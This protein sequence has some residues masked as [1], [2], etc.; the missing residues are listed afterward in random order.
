MLS[1]IPDNFI[2]LLLVITLSR[3]IRGFLGF[4]SAFVKIPILAFLYSPLFAIAFNIII[5]I[6][7]TIYL[8]YIGIK[9]CKFKEV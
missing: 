9:T 4:A 7:T 6:P 5:K 2:F 1:F 8:T 3:F